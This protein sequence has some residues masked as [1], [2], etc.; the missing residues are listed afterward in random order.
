[1]NST[2]QS[3]LSL[4]GESS[5][6]KLVSTACQTALDPY[7]NIPDDYVPMGMGPDFQDISDDED[8]ENFGENLDDEDGYF[9]DVRQCGECDGMFEAYNKEEYECDKCRGMAFWASLKI[10]NH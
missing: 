5:S 9:H 1:M 3:D 7:F 10:S 6:I 4:G 8:S 2:G